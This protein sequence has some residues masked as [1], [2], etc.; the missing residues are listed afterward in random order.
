[1]TIVRQYEDGTI[2]TRSRGRFD[3][4]CIYVNNRAPFDRNYFGQL[5]ELANQFN[6]QKIYNDFKVLYE[7][8]N[9]EVEQHIFE[10]LIPSIATTYGDKEL[11][12][13]KLFGT[14]YMVML[15]EQNRY[16]GRTKT[17]LGKRV[18]GLAAYQILFENYTIEDACDFSRGMLW[19][20]IAQLCEERNIPR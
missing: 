18:K 15:A 10:E 16:I 17:K 11:E 7:N 19:R 13:E 6:S 8:T 1:M 12:V 5:L 4:W 9:E 2:I 3:D 20:E 14:L